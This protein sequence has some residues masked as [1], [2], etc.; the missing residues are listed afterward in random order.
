[1][2]L[3]LV[4]ESEESYIS[5]VKGDKTINIW[6][7]DIIKSKITD[8]DFGKIVNF[9]IEKLSTLKGYLVGSIIVENIDNPVLVEFCIDDDENINIDS[10]TFLT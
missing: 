9:S 8:K 2:V 1:M 10:I 7:D 6:C 4:K 3:K 5:I